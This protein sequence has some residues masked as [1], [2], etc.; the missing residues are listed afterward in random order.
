[1]IQKLSSSLEMVKLLR[2]LG[3][4]G[5]ASILSQVCARQVSDIPWLSAMWLLEHQPPSKGNRHSWID[6]LSCKS[7]P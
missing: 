7:L 2:A 3:I 4:R 5:G 1:M 6:T